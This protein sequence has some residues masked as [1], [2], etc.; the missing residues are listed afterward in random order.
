M[1]AHSTFYKRTNAGQLQS[2]TSRTING[3]DVPV[4][5]IGDSVYPMLL[6]VMKPHNL[7]SL[8]SAEKCTYNNRISRGCIVTER[9]FGQLKACWRRL[10]KQNDMHNKNIPTIASAACSVCTLLHCIIEKI[11][12]IEEADK[13]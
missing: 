12:I 3:V 8:D 6:W 4:F 13:L 10:L 2:N 5:V 1:L 7:T 11:V 9:V